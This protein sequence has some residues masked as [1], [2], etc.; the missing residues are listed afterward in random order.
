M[1]NV[2][3]NIDNEV[4]DIATRKENL[5]RGYQYPGYKEYLDVPDMDINIGDTFDGQDITPNPQVRAEVRKAALQD[6]LIE[7]ALRHDKAVELGLLDAVA[8][9]K[10]GF[11]QCERELATLSS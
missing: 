9:H 2:I 4:V 3:C 1:L 10:R 7:L 8:R 5:S 6:Q 11:E